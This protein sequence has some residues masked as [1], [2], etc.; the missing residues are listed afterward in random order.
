VI[1]DDKR[2]KLGVC[3]KARDQVISLKLGDEERWPHETL[4]R[5]AALDRDPLPWVRRW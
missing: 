3:E 1:G 2:N 4:M 5:F